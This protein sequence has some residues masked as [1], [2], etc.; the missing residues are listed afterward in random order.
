MVRA[1]PLI[2]DYTKKSR[3]RGMRHI[4][5]NTMFIYSVKLDGSSLS[6]IMRLTDWPDVSA[7]N[8][9][10]LER[11]LSSA[12]RRAIQSKMETGAPVPMPRSKPS[13]QINVYLTASESL[14]VLV[15]NEI[16]KSS[17]THESLAKALGV[18]SPSLKCALDLEHPADLDLLSSAIN[19]VGKRLI[20]YIS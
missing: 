2:A 10:H 18:T 20:A 19:A 17:F 1:P 9:V 3:L 15:H 12:L 13:S 5:P 7:S 14:K 8:T 16:L 6:P 4:T 11:T